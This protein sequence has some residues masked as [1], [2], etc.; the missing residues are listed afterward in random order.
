MSV[1]QKRVVLG[2]GS[3]SQDTA[4]LITLARRCQDSLGWHAKIM[5]IEDGHLGRS[6]ADMVNDAGIELVPY[7]GDLAIKERNPFKRSRLLNQ[8][9]RHH[10]ERILQATQPD[11]VLTTTDL[12]NHSF[13]P[14][15]TELGIP[16]VFMQWTEIMSLDAHR[17]WWRAETRHYDRTRPFGTRYRRRLGRT[18]ERLAGFRNSWLMATET[19]VTAVQ[20]PFYKQTAIEGGVPEN[21]I[22]VTGNP[23]CDEIYAASQLTP[24]RLSDVGERIGLK[25]N[26]RYILHT[27]EHLARVRHLDES[28]GRRAQK[29]MIDSVREAAPGFAIV[30]KLHPKEGAEEANAIRAMAN[31]VVVVNA[32]VALGPLIAGCDILVSTTSSTLLWALGIDRPAISAYLWRGVDDLR[33]RRHWTGVEKVDSGAGLARSLRN[34]LTDPAHAAEWRKRRETGRR[35]LLLLDGKC[36]ERM[37]TLLDQSVS[38]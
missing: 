5:V 17:A 37:G 24:S 21:K 30:V 2:I 10:S 12:L 20:S 14:T 27:R 31:D 35:E 4:A 1:S 34:Y 6:A 8:A 19:T 15:A 11:V 36:S 33:L 7:P 32:E 3:Y 28:E 29:E 9:G 25:P 22:V 18:M 13:F 23:Q 26:Q 38:A 16:S